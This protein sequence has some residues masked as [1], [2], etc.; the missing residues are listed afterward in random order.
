LREAAKT[1]E[2]PALRDFAALNLLLL[3]VKRIYFSCACGE[4]SILTTAGAHAA[5][6]PCYSMME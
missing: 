3:T 2:C 5:K 4:I 1:S 6:L